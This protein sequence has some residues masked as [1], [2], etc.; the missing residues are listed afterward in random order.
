MKILVLGIGNILFA[1]EGAGVHIC[2]MIE[3]NYKFSSN[4]HSVDFIDGGTLAYRLLP[5]M[6][7]YDYIII[8]DCIDVENEKKGEVYFFDYENMPKSVSWQGSA[9]EV[10]MLQTLVMM[11][12]LGDRPPTKILGIIPDFNL[13]LTTKLSDEVIK[14]AEVMEKTLVKFLKDEFDFNISKINNINLQE[15]ANLSIQQ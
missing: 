2:K 6:G 14:G 1:D 3:A 8:L 13:E 12:L 15:I 5:I 4:L 7:E 10:E 11:D 9:H